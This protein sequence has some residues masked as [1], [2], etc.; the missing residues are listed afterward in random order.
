MSADLEFIGY[1]RMIN[2]KAHYIAHYKSPH[3]WQVRLWLFCVLRIHVELQLMPL[4][5]AVINL[6]RG[7]AH[8]FVTP[9]PLTLHLY[10]SAC[11]IDIA[12]I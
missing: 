5:L 8:H 3:N 10:R 4:I 11:G 7:L 9:P 12:S 6:H 1:F 2:C